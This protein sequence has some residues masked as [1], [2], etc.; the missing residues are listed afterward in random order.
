MINY[1]TALALYLLLMVYLISLFYGLALYRLVDPTE[2][3]GSEGD[4][5]VRVGVIGEVAGG[6]DQGVCTFDEPSL[7]K[8]VERCE[9]D[10][11]RCTSFYYDGFTMSYMVTPLNPLLLSPAPGGIYTRQIKVIEG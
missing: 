2:C 6:C 9:S 7:T 3:P 5:G 10:S 4:Y 11:V 8:A 1:W